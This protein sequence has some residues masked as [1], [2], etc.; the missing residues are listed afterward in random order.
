MV[1]P[2]QAGSH[3]RGGDDPAVGPQAATCARRRGAAGQWRAGA[4]GGP[5]EAM[6]SGYEPVHVARARVGASASER[7]LRAS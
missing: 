4:V 6:A 5:G 2:R 3:T 1:G 7:T